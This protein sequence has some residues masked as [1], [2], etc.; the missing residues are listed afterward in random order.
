MKTGQK[1][2]T[3]LGVLVLAGV[4]AQ[5]QNT[6]RTEPPP[7]PVKVTVVFKEYQGGKLVANLPYV[8]SVNAARRGNAER[9]DLRMG[10][11]V[12]ITLG[13]G[14]DYSSVGTNIDCTVLLQPDGPY[15]V[16]IA[17]TRSSV[18]RV[19][20][21]EP[22]SGASSSR[23]QIMGDSVPDVGISNQHPI[24]DNSSF[25]ETLLMRDGQTV[26][27]LMATDPVTGRVLKVDVTLNVVK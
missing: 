5:A 3:F 11:K 12:P 27:C 8:L 10:L 14:V 16:R 6:N 25:E 18:H 9:S 23:G 22:V 2:L 17:A 4:T 24:F 1:T 13:S 26:Q 7:V 20:N 19:T 15:A 21:G